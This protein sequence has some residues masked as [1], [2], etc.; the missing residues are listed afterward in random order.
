MQMF[1]ELGI[2]TDAHLEQRQEI[3]SPLSEHH[4]SKFDFCCEIV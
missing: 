3:A 4:T 1:A 2:L